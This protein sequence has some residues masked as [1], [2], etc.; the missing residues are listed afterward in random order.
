MAELAGSLPVASGTPP[1]RS[2][3]GRGYFV[4]G[5]TVLAL[6]F[7]GL[8]AWSVF[9]PFEGA[10]LA[11]GSVAVESRHKAIQHLEGGIVSE[12]LVRDGDRVSEGDLL[13]RLDET[14][15]VSELDNIDAMLVDL[16]TRE[17]RLLAERDGR[18]E[19]R[20]RDLPEDFAA[21]D[22]LGS[23]LVGQNRLLETRTEARTTRER[24][25]RQRI[26]QLREQIQGLQAEVVARNRQL[27]LITDELTDLE[28]LLAQGLAQRPRV[29]AL[30]REAAQIVGQMD[31]LNS[32]IAATGVQIG[33]AELEILSIT[34]GF[35]EE[36]IAELSDVQAQIA[37]LL[38]QR[39]AAADQLNRID[40]RAPRAGLV[41][42]LRA[43]T[44]GGVI[45]PGEPLMHIVPED[46]RLVSLVR[47][48][49]QDIDKISVGQAARLRFSAFSAEETPEV[50]AIV[51][52]ISA[53]AL[54]DEA[55]G[56]LYYEVII[57]LPDEL[58]FDEQ[59][60]VVPGMPVDAMLQTESRNVLSYLTKPLQ[61]AISRTFRE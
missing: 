17:A 57:E 38:S 1:V 11:H 39:R 61:D 10:V 48:M 36:V 29:L 2:S 20:V 5:F 56:M 60:V 16:L 52:S 27:M 23:A 50:P 46:D 32:Q 55:T 18:S 41:L 9:A 34:V 26:S 6:V 43:H 45:A 28:E 35:Q 51:H 12:I 59:F 7:G 24:I 22:G 49:P 54:Q 53:D 58:P 37:S 13:V 31:S 40:I 21:L 3:S 4:I 44:L 19:A 14:A 47:V 33:E 42:G 25:L 30:Q 8:I 15:I